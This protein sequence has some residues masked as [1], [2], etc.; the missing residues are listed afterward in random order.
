[1][2]DAG[3]CTKSEQKEDQIIQ[4]HSCGRDM[5]L[6]N[7]QMSPDVEDSVYICLASIKQKIFVYG[8]YDGGPYGALSF[9]RYYT[10]QE[11]SAKKC[12]ADIRAFMESRGETEYSRL[13]NCHRGN[14]NCLVLSQEMIHRRK[15]DLLEGRLE[16]VFPVYNE[17]RKYY[18]Y[19]DASRMHFRCS[20]GEDLVQ[21]GSARYSE[22]TGMEDQRFI[23]EFLPGILNR[24]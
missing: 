12:D 24:E 8:R 13:L 1:M 19:H 23:E 10:K 14:M 18:C 4:C 2:F 16:S 5:D 7:A 20:C 9:S 17:N 11:C 22:L 21:I 15:E 6:I 3:A